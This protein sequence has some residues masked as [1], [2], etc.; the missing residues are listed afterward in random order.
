MRSTNRDAATYFPGGLDMATTNKPATKNMVAPSI[1]STRDGLR[2]SP[3]IAPITMKMPQTFAA[4]V[5]RLGGGGTRAAMPDHIGVRVIFKGWGAVD[6]ARLPIRALSSAMNYRGI[7]Y[8]IRAGI[9][10]NRWTVSIHPTGFETS[11]R[12]LTAPRPKAAMLAQSMIDGWLSKAA[13]TRSAE[14]HDSCGC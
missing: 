8:T 4:F 10:R 14:R 3:K 1:A 11:E 9:E 12:V 6:I 13:G 7:R 2:S 5:I